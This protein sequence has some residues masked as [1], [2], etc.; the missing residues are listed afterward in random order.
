MP[1]FLYLIYRL[2]KRRFERIYWYRPS[3]D[4]RKS[5]AAW[6]RYQWMCSHYDYKSNEASVFFNCIRNNKSGKQVNYSNLTGSLAD[7]FLHSKSSWKFD[8]TFALW[9]LPWNYNKLRV[10]YRMVTFCI[11]CLHCIQQYCF[12]GYSPL[13]CMWGY[14]EILYIITYN[15]A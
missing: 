7:S 8:W 12:T 5:R 3:A 9:N 1:V 11:L 15:K 6:S 10:G 14:L 13:F 4:D 2:S